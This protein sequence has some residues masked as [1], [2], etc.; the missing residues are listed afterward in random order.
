MIV[1]DAKGTYQW[2]KV[3]GSYGMHRIFLDKT[4]RRYS[5]CDDSGETPELADDGVLWLVPGG[6]AT[7][8]WCKFANG[9]V[10]SYCVD[11][12]GDREGHCTSRLHVL[13]YLKELGY[14]IDIDKNLKRDLKMLFGVFLKLEFGKEE[15]E[16]P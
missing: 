15:T 6:Q 4:S 12:H 2:T 7:V 8:K 5:V 14:E 3:A 16:K 1:T 11:D 9:L 13:P 10:V